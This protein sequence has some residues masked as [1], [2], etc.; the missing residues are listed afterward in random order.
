MKEL[1]TRSVSGLA[2]S[3]PDSLQCFDR[4]TGTLS[5]PVAHDLATRTSQR[6]EH[7]RSAT[8]S[9]IARRSG[10]KRITGEPL[11][12][13]YGDRASEGIVGEPVTR[14]KAIAKGSVAFCIPGSANIAPG[15]CPLLELAE[16]AGC[17]WPYALKRN[18]GNNRE[19]YADRFRH[20]VRY[21]SESTSRGLRTQT[22]G[23]QS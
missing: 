11:N 16:G 7:N 19:A 2:S 20:L 14:T 5:N 8:I 12:D 13:L 18:S 3:A 23:R 17:E 6:R 4:T 21:R 10:C 1:G 22:R 9:A 15:E